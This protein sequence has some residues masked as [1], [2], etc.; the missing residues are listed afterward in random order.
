M[1]LVY[2]TP[3]DGHFFSGYYDKSP[4]NSKNNILL[5][6]KTDFIDRLPEIGD[7]AKLGFFDINK[8]DGFHPIENIH[9]FNWQQSNMLQWLGPNHDNE[10]IYNN[11]ETDKF[12]SKILNLENYESLCHDEPIYS[13]SQKGDV[14]FTIDFERHF[15]CRRGYAY[16]NIQERNK[17]VKILPGDGIGKLDLKTGEAIKIIDIETLID[18]FN[19]NSMKKSTNWVEHVMP[20]PDCTRIAFLHRWRLDSGEIFAHL[21]SCDVDGN[22]IR[23]LNNSGRFSHFCWQNNQTIFGWGSSNSTI[24]R[25]RKNMSLITPL[26][27]IAKKLYRM[28]IKSNPQIGLT[29]VSAALTGDS[30][31]F[32]DENNGQTKKLNDKKMSRDG[33]PSFSTSM[34]SI[35]LTD[36][37][38]DQG[39]AQLITYNISLKK[40]LNSLDLKSIKQFDSTACRCDLH[41]KWS[42]DGNYIS[43]DTMDQGVRSIYVYRLD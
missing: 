32:I 24:A 42:F 28:V 43:V 25:L 11:F 21:I 36:T 38:P 19:V 4:L 18:K 40:I 26:L 6:L 35:L 33:H 37:Y 10:I 29:N 13:V 34:P 1:K 17:N 27:P 22:N 8:N 5:C 14:A 16:S 9:A 23:L 20:N 30:Y 39:K 2:R 15:W 31:L 3:I 41:P 12:I 7:K